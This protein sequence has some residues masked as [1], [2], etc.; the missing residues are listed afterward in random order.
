[1]D[2]TAIKLLILDVDGVLTDGKISATPTPTTTPTTAD[3]PTAT[4]GGSD[5]KRFHV[6][7]GFAI[8]VWRECGGRVAILS[9]RAS[10]DVADRAAELG[11]EFV[12]MGQAKKMPAYEEICREASC[13]DSEV[14]YIGDDMP[15]LGPM[16]R[17]ALGI[18]VGDAVSSV[19]RVAK[20]VTSRRG[21]DGAVAE[22]IEW[23]L[24]KQG[25]WPLEQASSV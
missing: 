1:M 23:I 12:R 17:C 13:A 5:G 11:I 21:G 20:Y 19:K 24:R 25:R 3:S 8:K 10:A 7:D 22:A 18:A 6:R 2:F 4:G 16:A 14:A 15:D 9:G